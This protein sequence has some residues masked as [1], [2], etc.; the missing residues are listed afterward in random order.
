MSSHVWGKTFQEDMCLSLKKSHESEIEKER[1][2]V[3]YFFPGS[4]CPFYSWSGTL[5]CSCLCCILFCLGCALISLSLV[6]DWRHVN[7]VAVLWSGKV[8]EL[9]FDLKERSKAGGAK[10]FL[11][12]TCYVHVYSSGKGTCIPCDFRLKNAGPTSF[13][14]KVE[15]WKE[16]EPMQ[17]K[18]WKEMLTKRTKD[19]LIHHLVNWKGGRI[20]CPL[21][22][23]PHRPL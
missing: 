19:N 18:A 16:K 9:H 23:D 22:L 8:T 2:V 7:G 15:R 21:K 20:D 5:F 11:I 6:P 3:L 13:S 4:G 12:L 1:S 17:P 10:I 14:F